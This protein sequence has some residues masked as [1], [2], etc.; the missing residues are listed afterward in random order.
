M[1]LVAH[2]FHQ[3]ANHTLCILQINRIRDIHILAVAVNPRSAVRKR[4]HVIRF[5]R[6]PAWNR[7]GRRADNDRNM[8]TLGR[9]EHPMQRRK[10]KFSL[11]L[12]PCAPCGFRNTNHIHAGLLHHGHVLFYAIIWHIFIIICRSI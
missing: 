12:F 6:Q 1:W 10:I 4:K 11:A 8:M 9:I 3:F 2:F 5:V 7:I